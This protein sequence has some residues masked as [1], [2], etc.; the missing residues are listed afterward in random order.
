MSQRTETRTAH[1]DAS[2]EPL[3]FTL[4]PHDTASGLAGAATPGGPAQRRKLSSVVRV[5]PETYRRTEVSPADASGVRLVTYGMTEEFTGGIT[6]T[7]VAQ[8]VGV[9]R[10]DGSG[11]LTGVERIEGTLGGRTGA[12][13]ISCAGYYDADGVAHGR[14]TAVAGSGTGELAG[15]HAEGDFRVAA[16]APGG[17]I[18]I[19]TATYWF[20]DETGSDA[21]ESR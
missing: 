13:V 9:L 2:L 11:S 1:G 15:L 6:G 8:H 4:P 20:E 7:G 14:W 16:G 17:P 12:F 21:N 18:A 19:D 10:A 3:G 5:L